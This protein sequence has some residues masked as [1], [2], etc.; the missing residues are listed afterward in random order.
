VAISGKNDE[1]IQGSKNPVQKESSNKA[2]VATQQDTPRDDSSTEMNSSTS[3]AKSD[4]SQRSQ[5]FP[6]YAPAGG[7]QPK[8]YLAI[9]DENMI[10]PP[11]EPAPTRNAAD[12]EPPN[13]VPRSSKTP[14]SYLA[15]KDETMVNVPKKSPEIHVN[16]QTASPELPKNTDPGTKRRSILV[17]KEE[18]TD[19]AGTVENSS[20]GDFSSTRM[21]F[22]VR[23]Q[24]ESTKSTALP[25][26]SKAG[27]ETSL[28]NPLL[29]QA[30]APPAPKK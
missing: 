2:T 13:T 29:Q 10:N 12:P 5:P 30:L 11:K 24:K 8:F 7:T 26:E 18:S 4:V 15:I 25:T 3:T 22:S 16:E 19:V 17:I 14:I 9:K 28:N 6:P 23:K 1:F 21:P 27:A 20:D